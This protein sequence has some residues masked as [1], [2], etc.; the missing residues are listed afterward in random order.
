MQSVK[1]T[2]ESKVF[3][4]HRFVPVVR[5]TDYKA[6]TASPSAE[7]LGYSLSVRFADEDKILF[8]AR[9]RLS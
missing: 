9:P 7:A 4:V 1:R 6:P 5:F 8:E 3:Q 2:A